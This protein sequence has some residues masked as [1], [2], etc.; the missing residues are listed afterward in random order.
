MENT[1]INF[2]DID[3]LPLQSEQTVRSFGPSLF[4]APH[5]DDESLGCGGTIA[6]LRK[7][8]LPVTIVA[9]S[10]GTQSHPNS[11]KFPHD[12][13]RELRETELL[14]AAAILGVDEKEILF[15]RLPD[16]QVPGEHSKHF[17]SALRRL[18]LLIKLKKPQ[19]IFVSCRSDSHPDHR[20]A[21]QLVAAAK[22]STHTLFEYPI[23]SGISSKV[24]KGFSTPNITACYLDI[25]SVLHLKKLAISTYASQLTNLIDDDPG[26][27]RLSPADLERFMVKAELFFCE[28]SPLNFPLNGNGL[29]S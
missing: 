25:S 27:F 17:K 10:D 6:L 26:C 2:I 7:C 28:S 12:K 9:L 11:K 22:D 21:F 16:T 18:Q 8:G 15:F 29:N 19:S 4:V 1:I 13:L 24:G 23:W 5:P 3:H 14:T 20:A